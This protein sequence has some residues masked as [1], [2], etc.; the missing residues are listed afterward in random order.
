MEVCTESRRSSTWE[1]LYG[2]SLGAPPHTPKTAKS[3]TPSAIQSQQP[4][5]KNAML[6]FT[7]S[8]RTLILINLNKTHLISCDVP[9][10]KISFFTPRTTGIRSTSNRLR[11]V[12]L[13]Y[14]SRGGG[15]LCKLQGITRSRTSR[16]HSRSRI[17]PPS[18]FTGLQ[19]LSFRSLS[20]ASRPI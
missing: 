11:F 4:T 19:C 8:V 7:S 13:L 1:S 20:C 10:W 3:S 14:R 16:T 15:T 9:A 6:S 18:N 17:I 5:S 2:F 12:C